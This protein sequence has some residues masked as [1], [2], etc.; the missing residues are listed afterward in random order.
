MKLSRKGQML[1]LIRLQKMRRRTGKLNLYR[2]L[3]HLRK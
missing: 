1:C 2:V 3:K